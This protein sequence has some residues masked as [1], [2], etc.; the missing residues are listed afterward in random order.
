MGVKFLDI[1]VPSRVKNLDYFGVKIQQLL[2]HDL[3][4]LYRI[5]FGK[6]TQLVTVELMILH[7]E[8]NEFVDVH[9]HLLVILLLFDTRG[10]LNVFW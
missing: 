3:V 8:R 7:I 1:S 10:V 4:L 9:D 5:V 2:P 6:L